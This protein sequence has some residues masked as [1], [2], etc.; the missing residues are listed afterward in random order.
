[1]LVVFYGLFTLAIFAKISW[2]ISWQFQIA[3]VNYWRFCSV[4]NQPPVVYMGDLKLPRNLAQ[5]IAAEI[6][7]VNGPLCIID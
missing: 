7:S 5:K 1:M 6:A 4:L 3:R 2:R